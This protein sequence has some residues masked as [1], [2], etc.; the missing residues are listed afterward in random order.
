MKL[1]L[2]VNN[3]RQQ[4]DLIRQEA[5]PNL[6]ISYHYFRKGYAEFL[7]YT[8]GWQPENMIIDSGAFSVWTK[9]GRIDIDMY[10]QYCKETLEYKQTG[11]NMYFVNLDVLP[12][13]FGRYPSQEEREHS[14]EQGWKNMEYM[15]NHGVKVI[16][17]FHQHEDF[18]WLRK[19]A[20]HQEY[21]GLSPANDESQAS[22]NRWLA[23]CFAMLK[24]SRKT[25]GFAVT[26][27]KTLLTFP[28]YS[29][30]SSSWIQ[31]GKYASIPTFK[32]GKIKS[33]AFKDK[34]NLSMLMDRVQGKDIDIL[35]DY[36]PRL[37]QGIRAYRA[38]GDYITK[39]WEERGIKWD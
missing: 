8:Q 31:G 14:A 10:I 2:A 7:D 26:S 35:T 34:E 27:V 28:F 22:K 20:D 12:G 33:I 15:E 32:D 1:F 38:A 24:A 25:H 11:N 23:K 3:T 9:N 13:N 17:V 21:I 6:L 37:R 4:L 29:G 18:S 19:L 5:Y 39:V 36:M 16:H 30:D